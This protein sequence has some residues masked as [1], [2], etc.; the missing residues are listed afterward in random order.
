V[1]QAQRFFN[2]SWQIR[3][4]NKYVNKTQH[5]LLG[6][7]NQIPTQRKTHVM[8]WPKMHVKAMRL[9]P[10]KQETGKTGFTVNPYW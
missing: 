7:S 3:E 4:I 1:N 2:W 9:Y 6:E 10:A 8:I 5:L